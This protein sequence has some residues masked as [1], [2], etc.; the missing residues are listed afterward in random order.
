MPKY[1][2]HIKDLIIER[3]SKT[4]VVNAENQLDAR[5]KAVDKHTENYFTV[6]Q[7]LALYRQSTIPMLSHYLNCIGL[8]IE[9][10]RKK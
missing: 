10:C 9:G 1:K 6:S 3:E 8:K 5:K 7:R 2:V 4:H